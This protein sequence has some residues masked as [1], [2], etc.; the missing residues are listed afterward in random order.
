M[1]LMRGV[2][3]LAITSEEFMDLS[4]NITHTPKDNLDILDQ[5]KLPEIAQALRNLVLALSS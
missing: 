5:S 4:T 2:P 1:F 3:A